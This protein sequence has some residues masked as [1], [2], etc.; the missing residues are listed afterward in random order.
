MPSPSCGT[1]CSPARNG[2]QTAAGGPPD[3]RTSAQGRRPCAGGAHGPR[4]PGHRAVEDAG[5][6]RIASGPRPTPPTRPA[7]CPSTPASMESDCDG[8]RSPAADRCSGRSTPSSRSAVPPT[9]RRTTRRSRP[10]PTSP[11]RSPRRTTGSPSA[12]MTR[13]PDPTP[14]SRLRPASS[15]PSRP[16]PPTS[17][18][19]RRDRPSRPRR[20]PASRPSQAIFKV[21]KTNPPPRR[22]IFKVRKTN[23]PP[24]FPMT[25]TRKTR[26]LP[27]RR[28][29]CINR[30]V[31][32]AWVVASSIN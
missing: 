31:R 16:T 6:R 7:G 3:R 29:S 26:R 8:S 20:H 4:G 23:P 12:T 1:N 32:T 15:H 19:A 18:P 10:G 25:Q 2:S 22:A 11:S 28:S 9:R 14:P 24:R 30:D 17:R 21:R 13:R 27:G 5:R